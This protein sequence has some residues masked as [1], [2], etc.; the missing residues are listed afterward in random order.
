MGMQQKLDKAYQEGYEAGQ[1]V[2][3]ETLGRMYRNEGYI[4]GAQ[5]TWDAIERMIPQL[6]G[7]GPKT[8][9]KLLRAIQA[10]AKIEKAR[11]SRG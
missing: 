8:T 5:A 11:L 4:L 6:Q 7:V 9:E 1:K 2:H 10:Q 3:N